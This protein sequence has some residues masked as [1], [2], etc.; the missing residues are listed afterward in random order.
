MNFIKFYY[1]LK[2]SSSKLSRIMIMFL[3]RNTKLT[4]AAQ[5]V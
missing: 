5:S 1:D 2:S 4:T 3:K